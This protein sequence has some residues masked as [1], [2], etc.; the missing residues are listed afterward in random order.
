[1]ILQQNRKEIEEF[2]KKIDN[3]EDEFETAR[4]AVERVK[5]KILQARDEGRDQKATALQAELD[6]AKNNVEILELAIKKGEDDVHRFIDKKIDAEL[7][8]F[9][10]RE[11]DYKYTGKKMLAQIGT[12]LKNC[13]EIAKVLPG[14]MGA[15]SDH[16]KKSLEHVSPDV[17]RGRAD[18]DIAPINK[19]V[20]QGAELAL[21]RNLV[22]NIINKEYLINKLYGKARREDF[23]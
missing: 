9:S 3:T 19:F 20:T 18:L 12:N 14:G 2:F 6:A 11:A 17:L 13:L 10:Q 21:L 22:K 8:D 15:S 23:N 1:M 16:I 7:K 5:G 4:L